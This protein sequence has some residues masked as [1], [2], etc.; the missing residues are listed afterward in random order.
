MK[1]NCRALH[2]VLLLLMLTLVFVGCG[3]EDVTKAHAQFP[4]AY[5]K[6]DTWLV[7]WYI[8]G[9]DLESEHGA[10][11][12]DLEELME[13]E[14]PPNVRVLI[15]AGGTQAWQN[16][17][18]EHPLNLY[19]YDA[20]GLHEL[21]N[22]P[23]AD[24]G[25]AETL[26]DFLHYGEENYPADHRVFVF[27]DHGGGS[28]A[29]VCYDERTENMLCLNDIR[30]A[31][32]N[33][34]G[35][36][37]AEPPY[38]VVGFDACLMASYETAATLAG[39]TR[40]MVASEEMEPGNG[41][42]YDAWVGALADNP[43]MGGARLGEVICDSYLAGCREEDTEEE[44]TLSVIDLARLP[45]LTSAY[46]TYSRDVLARASHLSPAFF[47]ALDRA[48]QRAE[49]YGG[50]T[51]EMG[52]ANMVDLAGLA[53][54]TAR[55]FPSAAALVRAVDD[56]CIYKVHGDYRRR[57]GGISSYYSYDGDEDGF[58][59]YV[60]QDAALMEQKCLLYTMLY[61]ELPDEAEEM[62]AGRSNMEHVE[63]LPT[64]RRQ[65]FQVDA[66]EDRAVDVDAHGNAF[67]RLSAA[68]MDGLTSVRCN[69][70]YIGEEEGVVLYLGS[71]TNVD[72]DWD[73]GV[74]K[75]NFDGTWPML[76]GHPV[77]IEI[78]EEGDDYNL[79]SIPIKLNGRECN[80]QVA[81]SYADE[82]YRILGARR[83]LEA[84]GMSDRNL[85]RLRPG[86]MVTTI[87]YAMSTSG[88]DEDFTPVEV[89]TF[90]LGAH[91]EVRDEEVGDGKYGYLFEF[92]APAG[93]SA[94]SDVAVFE[95]E[96]GD[97]TTSVE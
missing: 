19:L 89:D 88:N 72:A 18:F 87:H 65:I 78:V 45:A 85:I 66:L 54:E 86:D 94:L 30:Q 50:N 47:A 60:D 74:F 32:S 55:E 79:Y 11:S 6:D 95:I 42:N 23:D 46:E 62:L 82:R 69:L 93:E 39:Y 28:A 10:A 9:S 37:P 43:A 26:T 1:P 52:Y 64:A 49:N 25:R 16:D 13:T 63:A 71:D 41:W 77:Y 58:S 17:V 12:A 34:Y 97:I 35:E 38:E 22:L 51:R 91:P 2:A 5:S 4:D 76:D 44:A 75:D 48:A 40:Y 73:S 53:Q 61:G 56:A 29:G 57:G 31:F 80:L 8:C 33:V 84:N 67:V 96:N 68:E 24:M 7:S 3:E 27:W 83:G 36:H 92:I 21:K 15:L 14:L 20:D 90:R 59:A 81:Y 70:L